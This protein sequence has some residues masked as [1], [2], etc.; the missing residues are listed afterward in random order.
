MAQYDMRRACDRQSYLG[1]FGKVVEE[2]LAG[3]WRIMDRN[4]EVHFPLLTDEEEIAY[5]R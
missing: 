3:G 4:M 2:G 1:S 5:V